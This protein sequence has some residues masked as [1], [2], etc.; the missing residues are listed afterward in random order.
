MV[1]KT[2]LLFIAYKV[3]G[4]KNFREERER[5]IEQEIS[6]SIEMM[7]LKDKGLWKKKNIRLLE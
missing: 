1:L 3:T 2:L 6:R 5:D 4:M 7:K